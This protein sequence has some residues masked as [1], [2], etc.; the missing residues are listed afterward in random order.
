MLVRAKK[1][2]GQHFLKSPQIAEQ[3]VTSLEGVNFD[4]VF[5]IGAGTGALTDFILAKGCYADF[6]AVE[7]DTESIQYL[8]KRHPGL[9]IT[10]QDFLQIPLENYKRLGLIGNLPYNIASLI[11]FKVFEN[12]QSVKQA[13]FMVQKE[14]GERICSKPNSKSNGI[15]S[16]LLQTYYDAQ[17]LF[18]VG[19]EHFIP[20]PKVLSAVIRLT[21]N[22]RQE[23]L[24]DKVLY[25]KVVKMSFAQRRKTLKNALSQ[26][27]DLS[28]AGFERFAPLRA[29]QLGVEDFFELTLRIQNITQTSHVPM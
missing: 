21:R 18:T 1:Y 3:I 17:Y 28:Q 23:L 16:I 10:S 15:L 26:F 8:Q 19:R 9:K 14:V 22:N 7:I 6:E 2:L 24:C 13:V 29:E 20:P 12:E 11:L 25:K 5:E 27:V 4:K